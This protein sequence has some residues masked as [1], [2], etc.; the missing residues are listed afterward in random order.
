MTYNDDIT[1]ARL[2]EV[3]HYDPETGI[4]R[5]RVSRGGKRA[6]SIAGSLYK[7]GYLRIAIDGI[8]YR[9][10]RLAWLYMTGEWP[11]EEIDH[12]K[13]IRDDNRW[14]KLRD[15]TTVENRRNV[16]RQKNNSSGFKG[17][18]WHVRKKKWVARIAIE[19]RRLH[20]G[21]YDSK[22]AAYEAYKNA[23]KANFG[24]FYTERH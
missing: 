10:H 7:S 1:H 22:E 23:A 19:K 21:M 13:G 24:E 4:F 11:K 16:K 14:G 20:I 5:W 18:H 3:L 8:T 6:G 17:V 15:A 9:G 12:I 2:C